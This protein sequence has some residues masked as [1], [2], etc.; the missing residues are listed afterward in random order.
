MTVHAIP[1][2]ENASLL[3]QRRTSSEVARRGEQPTLRGRGGYPCNFRRRVL[4]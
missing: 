2:D 1:H 4:R 3:V